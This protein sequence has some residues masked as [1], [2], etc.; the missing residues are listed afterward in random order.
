[1]HTCMHATCRHI[2]YGHACIH[3][4]QAGSIVYPEVGARRALTIAGHTSYTEAVNAQ[5]MGFVNTAE[6]IALEKR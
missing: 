3:T 1:M 2:A 6:G 5:I 4:L